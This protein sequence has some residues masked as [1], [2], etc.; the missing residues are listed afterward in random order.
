VES[1]LLLWGLKDER[2]LGEY[3]FAPEALG[4]FFT[5]SQNSPS[6]LRSMIKPRLFGVLQFSVSRM[7][8]PHAI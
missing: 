3:S 7:Y 6:R 2:S 5:H 1:G 4:S 8:V